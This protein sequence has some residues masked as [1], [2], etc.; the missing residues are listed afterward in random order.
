VENGFGNVERGCESSGCEENLCARGVASAVAGESLCVYCGDGGCWCGGRVDFANVA[1]WWRR[2]CL[3]EGCSWKA[4]LQVAVRGGSW[5]AE[6]NWCSFRTKKSV[7][8]KG[9]VLALPSESGGIEIVVEGLVGGIVGVGVVVVVGV[10][11]AAVVG[12]V[13]VGVGVVAVVVAAVVGVVGV[14]VDDV[15]A[16]AVA[17]A[18][19][20]V[21]VVGVSLRSRTSARVGFHLGQ[22]AR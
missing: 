21:V 17:V 10:G 2:E 1:S 14:V 9:V 13:A 20:V 19:V 7:V 12:V 3:S 18:V 16:V 22:L 8:G 4:G 6:E 11:V 15:V 5:I